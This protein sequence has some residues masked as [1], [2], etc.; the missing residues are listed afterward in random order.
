MPSVRRHTRYPFL[1]FLRHTKKERVRD[2][3]L[4]CFSDLVTSSHDLRACNPAGRALPRRQRRL[5]PCLHLP[6]GGRC[7]AGF[8]AVPFDYLVFSTASRRIAFMRDW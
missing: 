5:K 7:Q 6:R 4:N 3:P 1:A 2:S 8:E